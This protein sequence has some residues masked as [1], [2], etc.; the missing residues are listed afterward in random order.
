M[1][2]YLQ[3]ETVGMSFDTKKGP[4]VALTAID[5]AVRKGEFKAANELEPIYLREVSFVKSPPTRK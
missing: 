4:F 1:D 5:L 3:I 2:K